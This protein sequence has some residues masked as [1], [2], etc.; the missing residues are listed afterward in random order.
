[1]TVTSTTA[2]VWARVNL[3]SQRPMLLELN[4]LVKI[5][6]GWEKGFAGL[7]ARKKPALSLW[8]LMPLLKNTRAEALKSPWKDLLIM[9]KLML[10]YSDLPLEE[11]AQ[12]RID[13]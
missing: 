2:R 11:N 10:L 1:M 13:L 8:S 9:R 12:R 5:P 6:V 4:R 3:R 7:C